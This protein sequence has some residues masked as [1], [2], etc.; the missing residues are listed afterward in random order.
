MILLRFELKKIVK[1]R[2]ILFLI[3]V[4]IGCP[5]IFFFVAQNELPIER[6]RFRQEYSVISDQAG[7]KILGLETRLENTSSKEAV[8]KL[9]HAKHDI[10]FIQTKANQVLSDIDNRKTNLNQ[11]IIQL[12][13]ALKNYQSSESK[14]IA[15]DFL[16]SNNHINTKLIFFKKL[17]DK[18]LNYEAD[19]PTT[20]FPNFVVLCGRY[21]VNPLG[22]FLFLL[23]INMPFLLEYAE[24]H[25]SLLRLTYGL[26][27]RKT[28]RFY[29]LYQLIISVALLFLFFGT[30]AGVSQTFGKGL[31]ADGSSSWHYPCQINKEGGSVTFK[32]EVMTWLMVYFPLILILNRTLKLILIKS[33]SLFKMFLFLVMMMSLW[34]IFEDNQW[35]QLSQMSNLKVIFMGILVT[36]YVISFP[37]YYHIVAKD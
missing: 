6:D 24:G 3:F 25:T 31:L 30:A 2:L 27:S 8:R 1:S 7:N 5:V 34:K 26:N 9:T 35:F 20:Q 23:M 29:E 28:A 4:A 17:G 37:I 22:I 11:V 36:V 33:S 32:S 19:N 18:N 16:V 10:Q 13:G 12:F 21:F 15:G 14:I